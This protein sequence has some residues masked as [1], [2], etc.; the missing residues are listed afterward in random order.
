M[1]ELK[2]ELVENCP[3]VFVF[4]LHF[5]FVFD[6][7]QSVHDIHVSLQFVQLFYFQV[8]ALDVGA[9][10]DAVEG[11]VVVD[12][13]DGGEGDFGVGVK[14]G[15]L[16]AFGEEVEHAVVGEEERDLLLFLVEEGF[17]LFQQML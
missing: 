13:G 11:V 8:A 17:L 16:F 2:S 15:E 6:V 5:Y 4:L 14:V 10:V 9:D 3:A 1:N 7:V 12:E